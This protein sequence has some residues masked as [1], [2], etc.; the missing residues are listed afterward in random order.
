MTWLPTTPGEIR[1]LIERA[2]IAHAIYERHHTPRRD[3]QDAFMFEA[4]STEGW[5]PMSDLLSAALERIEALEQL[6]REAATHIASIICMR[7]AFTGDEPYVGW[8]GL[9]LA[10]NEALDDHDA[11]KARAESAEASLANALR[12]GNLVADRVTLEHAGKAYRHCSIC[13]AEDWLDRPLKHE[14]DC[15]IPMWRALPRAG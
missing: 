6:D 11:L 14:D 5:L 9:G 7:T 12:V 10:L 2:K 8:K 3:H 1:A 13:Y 4:L 15:P